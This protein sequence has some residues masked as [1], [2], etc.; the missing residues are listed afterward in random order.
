MD[1]A[2]TPAQQELKAR[3]AAYA[4][5]LMDYEDE[6]EQAGGPLPKETV[7]EA[8]PGGDGRRRVRHQHA[9]RNG[10]APGSPCSNRSSSRRSSA[11]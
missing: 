11:R 6:A 8:H 3:A 4:E 1:F 5:L 2:Y 9:R 10:A 7:D